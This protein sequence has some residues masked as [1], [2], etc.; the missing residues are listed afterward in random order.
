MCRVFSW[1]IFLSHLNT[2]LITSL[3]ISELDLPIFVLN[4]LGLFPLTF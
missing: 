4:P 1:H 3:L 2:I